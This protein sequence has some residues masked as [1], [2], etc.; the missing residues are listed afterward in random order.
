MAKSSD[1]STDG[2]I[3]GAT[4]N[5]DRRDAKRKHKDEVSSWQNVAF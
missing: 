1:T 3:P 2:A 4:K 5:K